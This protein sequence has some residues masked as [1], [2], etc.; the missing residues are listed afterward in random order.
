MAQVT[1]NH[2]VRCHFFLPHSP[3]AAKAINNHRDFFWFPN[4][5]AL[6][7][8]SLVLKTY[9]QEHVLATTVRGGDCVMACFPPHRL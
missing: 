7:F 3:T 5:S 2:N 8:H 6:L 1:T 4:F 9:P